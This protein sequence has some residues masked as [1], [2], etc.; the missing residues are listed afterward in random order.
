MNVGRYVCIVD[1]IVAWGGGGGKEGGLLQ[2]NLRCSA[3]CERE[4]RDRQSTQI[5]ESIDGTGAQT[6]MHAVITG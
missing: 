2:V 3:S 4:K 6:N 5:K 1:G